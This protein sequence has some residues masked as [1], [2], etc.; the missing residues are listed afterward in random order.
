LIEVLERV[1]PS[2]PDRP[3]IGGPDH[4]MRRVTRQV[5]FEPD[6]WTR[7]RAEKVAQLFDTMAA[8]WGERTS[9]ERREPLR[10]AL[11]RGGLDEP[12]RGACLEIGSG[13]GSSTG[14]LGRRFAQVLCIDLSREMLRHAQ[15]PAG[16]RI[17]ADAARLPV[18]DDAAAAVVLVNALLFPAEVD[19]VLARE[20]ALIWVNSLGERT[21]IHLSAEDVERA[22]PGAWQGVASRAGW[23]TWC[24]LRRAP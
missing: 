18:A 15:E 5:A 13:T 1:I 11:D 12:P 16:V 14:D 17:N 2:P 20:G 10:D 22:M 23:G 24:V 7:E 3:E 9:T 6:A 21:P 4:P 19:R 8:G